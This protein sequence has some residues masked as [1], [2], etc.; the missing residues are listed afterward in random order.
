MP[1]NHGC[2]SAAAPGGAQS[3]NP[4][5]FFSSQTLLCDEGTREESHQALFA[6][7]TISSPRRIGDRI[8]EKNRKP[9]S[10]AVPRRG[11]DAGNPYIKYFFLIFCFVES[12]FQAVIAPLAPALPPLG[13]GAHCDASVLPVKE[14]STQLCTG[15]TVFS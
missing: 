9:S 14:I 3:K 13:A 1:L 5:G 6:D 10:P 4:D 7:A 8:Q 11:P 15:N 2:D 12:L